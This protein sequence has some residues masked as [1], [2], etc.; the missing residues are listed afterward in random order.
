MPRIK[1]PRYQKKYMAADLSRLIIG[2]MKPDYRQ[3]DVADA[4][5]ISQQAFGQRLKTCNF[6]YTQLIE[7]FDLLKFTDDEILRSM[8]RKGIRKG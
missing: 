5:D 1:D 8:K 6:T 7:L 2:K 4:L 3:R